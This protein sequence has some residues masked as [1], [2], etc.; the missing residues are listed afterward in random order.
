MNLLG[1]KI[2]LSVLYTLSFT[3]QRSVNAPIRELWFML[4]ELRKDTT[5]TIGISSMSHKEATAYEELEQ[6][7]CRVNQREYA[8][9]HPNML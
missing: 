6:F 7:T 4:Q 2:V 3:E 5:C 1:A 9:K 8:V